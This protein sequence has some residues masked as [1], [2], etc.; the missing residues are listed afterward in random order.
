M[1]V[2]LQEKYFTKFKSPEEA[3]KLIPRG[4]HVFIGSGCG[5]PQGLVK[6][7][8]SAE[9]LVDVEVIQVLTLGLAPYVKEKY[10]AQFR[11]NAF[12]IGPHARKAVWE[13]RADY[14]PVFLS[15]VPRLF[16]TG[17]VHLDVAL[18][19]VSPPDENGYCSFGI[20]VDITKPAAENAE[21]V[22]AEINPHMPRVGGNSLMHVDAL[23]VLT[24]SSLP[25]LELPKYKVQEEVVERIG[26]SVAELVPDGATIQVGIGNIPNA[27]LQAL[28][29]K[30]DLGLHTEMLSDGV[31]ELITAGVITNKRKTLHPGK[32]VASFCMGSR[33]LYTFID[34]NP[35]FEFYPSDYVNNPFVIA[36][37]EK[38]VAINTALEVDL[39]GQ[40]CADSLGPR[41]YGGIG[42]HL[43][44]VRGAAR[45][46][47]GKP[48]IVLPS[49]TKR[50]RSTI[51][52]QLSP[53]A[54]VA[55]TRGD[56]H[57]VVTEYGT[58]YL[59]GKSVRER[60]LALIS[61]AHPQF[62][63]ELL[64][65]AKEYTYLPPDQPL[66]L[67]DLVEQQALATSL[68]LP[69]KT[70]IFF[71]PLSPADEDLVRDFFYA[72]STEAVYKRF[73]S[74]LK[75]FHRWLQIRFTSIDWEKDVGLIGVIGER[76]KEEAVALGQY[77]LDP[78][79]NMAEIGLIVRDDWQKKGIGTF[80]LRHLAEIAK[81]R[82]VKGLMGEILLD[83][84]PTRRMFHK[85]AAAMGSPVEGKI[86]W[87][88]SILSFQL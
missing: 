9:M 24:F 79:T 60:A 76:G 6:A 66:F 40:V 44:F 56:V 85:A 52:S 32:A 38:M 10:H 31:L 57:Y 67:A 27:I 61:I 43:D 50:G 64:K 62:R 33:K 82:K 25:L 54:G 23:D 3:V 13:G 71:R 18:I 7:L 75:S 41:F 74:P 46:L 15:E 65:A 51:V 63:A 78:S 45:A 8:A 80:L 42:G 5:E 29:D 77:Y 86:A 1:A 39:T 53:G 55:T 70:Q 84:Y 81:K 22:I 59:H 36:A 49:T 37:H 34:R 47:E 87:G 73:F 20:A 2:N 28:K 48:I 58:A 35:F 11:H 72:L 14:T 19:Q 83:N 12:F 16:K 26:K 4:A 88:V 68:M 69:D 30:K 21:L 17:Q